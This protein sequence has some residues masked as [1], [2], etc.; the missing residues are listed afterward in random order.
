MSDDLYRFSSQ[1]FDAA[2]LE[3][4]RESGTSSRDSYPSSDGLGDSLP[5][6][7]SND[8]FIT[9]STDGTDEFFNRD[10]GSI[11]SKDSAELSEGEI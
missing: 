7:F 3:A 5:S 2:A 4:T 10:S 6:A 11:A 8:S 1:I 9:R